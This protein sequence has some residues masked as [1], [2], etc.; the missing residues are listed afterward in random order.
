MSNLLRIE[1]VAQRL[2][3]SPLTVRKWIALGRLPVVRLGRSVRVK[4][5]DVHALVRLG[6]EPMLRD[7]GRR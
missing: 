6:Y 5:D 3:V 4:E 7:G 2:A 1:M